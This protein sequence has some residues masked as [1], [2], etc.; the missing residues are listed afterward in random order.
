MQLIS[1]LLDARALG[2]S[3][4]AAFGMTYEVLP[5]VF[6]SKDLFLAVKEML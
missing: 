3:Q 1:Y 2:E 5:S 4:V 6:D